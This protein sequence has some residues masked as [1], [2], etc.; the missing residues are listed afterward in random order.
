MQESNKLKISS[1]FIIERI[2]LAIALVIVLLLLIDY[3]RTHKD[4]PTGGLIACCI[5]CFTFYFLFT[6]PNVYYNEKS[7][8]IKKNKASEL[9]IPLENIKSIKLS[10]LGFSKYGGSWLLKY[11]TSDSELKS[12]R[13]YHSIFSNP[14]SK[15]IKAVENKNQKLVIRDWTFGWN[16]LFD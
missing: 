8:F 5:I 9:E 11:Y 2:I 1:D 10:V 16:E 4:F 13:I 15:F 14:F 6:R 3:P 12:V 7:M